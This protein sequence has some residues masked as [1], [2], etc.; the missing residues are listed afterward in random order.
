LR[1][2]RKVRKGALIKKDEDLQL[3][4]EAYVAGYYSCYDVKRETPMISFGNFLDLMREK[5]K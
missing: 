2:S 4:R 5:Y 3:M 1:V